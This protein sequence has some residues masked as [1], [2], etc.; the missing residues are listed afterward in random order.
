MGEI[1]QWRLIRNMYNPLSSYSHIIKIG[2]Y[3]LTPIQKKVLEKNTGDTYL[4]ELIDKFNTFKHCD[5][6]KR[7]YYGKPRDITDPNTYSEEDSR[8]YTGPVG[9]VYDDY[10]DIIDFST[11]PVIE[12]FRYDNCSQ[13]KCTC[14]HN[15]RNISKDKRCDISPS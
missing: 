6:C 11:K 15:M 12:T 4:K 14:R 7:H 2:L 13:C 10:D 5:C 9:G 3:D 8:Y 1:A